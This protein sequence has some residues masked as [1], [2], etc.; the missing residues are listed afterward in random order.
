MSQAPGLLGTPDSGH[1]SNAATSASC[2]RSSARPTSLTM[3]V[4]PAINFADSM[5][6]TAS[7][8]RWMSVPV[9]APNHIRATRECKAAGWPAAPA[10]RDTFHGGRSGERAARPLIELLLDLHHLA[11]LFRRCEHGREVGD[12]EQLADLDLRLTC[13]SRIRAA[14]GPFDSLGLRF[15]VEDPES[16]HELPGLAERTIDDLFVLPRQVDARTLR[17]RLQAIT[18]EQD[19]RVDELL[20]EL[21]HLHE[22]CHGRHLAP[23]RS[24]GRLDYQHESHGSAPW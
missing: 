11:T 24:I 5:R 13:T 17:A 14:P 22:G 2:A 4:S 8:V 18:G 21:S 10:D 12:V 15:H 9:T 19:A 23:L 6:Q 7:I 20:V 16:A 3:R 1:R